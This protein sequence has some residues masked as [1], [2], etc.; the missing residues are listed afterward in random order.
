MDSNFRK[1]GGSNG[2]IRQEIKVNLY[3]LSR[4]L[5]S[6]LSQ[7]MLGVQLDGIWHSGVVVYGTHIINV[8]LS[9]LISR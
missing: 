5:A 7:N 1:G 3:D 4:G 9:L 6:G 8:A 2:E